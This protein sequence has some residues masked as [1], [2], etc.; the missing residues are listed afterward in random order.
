MSKGSRFCGVRNQYK[1]DDDDCD[2]DNCYNNDEDING[3]NDNQDYDDND[4]HN[5]ND[6]YDYDNDC[7]CSI[8]THLYNR[9]GLRI[10]FCKYLLVTI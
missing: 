6:G 3:C 2:D 10:F 4:D 1:S 8:I 7:C 5:E 9:L